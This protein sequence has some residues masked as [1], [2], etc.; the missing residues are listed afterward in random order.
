MALVVFD[1]HAF[2][3]GA[4]AAGMTDQQ[5]EFLA[6]SYQTLLTDRIATKD[7]ITN[8]GERL[9]RLEVRLGHLEARMEHLEKR[10][11]RLEA[12]M[13]RLEATL[14]RVAGFLVAIMIS[15]FGAFA[16]FLQYMI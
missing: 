10:M 7:D 9:D 16:A 1:S 11:D 6:S 13:E 8:L 3:K 12:R 15:L 4:L 14:W 2:V 5:A